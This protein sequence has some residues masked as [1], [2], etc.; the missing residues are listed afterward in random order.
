MRPEVLA[1]LVPLAAIRTTS[2]ARARATAQGDRLG[3]VDFDEERSLRPAP[4]A[5]SS[6]MAWDVRLAGCPT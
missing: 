3:A 1:R 2:P 5:T 4:L 6:M